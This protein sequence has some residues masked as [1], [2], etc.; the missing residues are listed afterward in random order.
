M[1]NGKFK[2]KKKDNVATT[3]IIVKDEDLVGFDTSPV[4]NTLLS[5][6]LGSTEYYLINS[7]NQHKSTYFLYGKLPSDQ[8]VLDLCS[9]NINMLVPWVLIA[10]YDYYHCRSDGRVGSLISDQTFDFLMKQLAINWTKV[11]HK[12][13]KLLNLASLKS[14]SL[15][16]IRDH[17]YPEIVKSVTSQM[18]NAKLER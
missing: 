17:D 10:S 14:G 4:T 6:A 13:K 1:N 11:L 3:T 9:D 8:F 12:H 2:V 7:S 15:Y 5:D 18:I 16:Y